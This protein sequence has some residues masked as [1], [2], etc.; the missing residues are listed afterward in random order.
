MKKHGGL[1]PLEKHGSI[2][3]TEKYGISDVHY[4]IQ[5]ILKNS[6]QAANL[7]K[8]KKFKLKTF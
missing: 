4:C 1:D 3:H 7:R 8:I 5:K 6:I 2:D